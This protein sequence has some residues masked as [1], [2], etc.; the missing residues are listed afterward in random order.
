MKGSVCSGVKV[1]IRKEYI[2]IVLH[3]F[4][5]ERAKYVEKMHITRRRG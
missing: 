5:Q 3:M 2:N 1:S 4:Q